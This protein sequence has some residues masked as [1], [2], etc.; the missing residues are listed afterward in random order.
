MMKYDARGILS[1]IRVPTLVVS[2]DRDTTTK[3]EA[4][5]EIHSGIPGSS[6]VNLSPAK[7]L[8]LIE[9]DQEYAEAVRAHALEI[10]LQ[11][12]TI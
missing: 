11:R 2:G 4:S 6:L 12:T 8:G 10:V 3:P 9:Y 7:H 5:R 1:Q